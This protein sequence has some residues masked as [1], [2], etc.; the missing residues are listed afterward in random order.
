MET[1]TAEQVLAACG[2]ADNISR[3]DVCMTRLRVTVKDPSRLDCVQLKNIHRVLGI[4]RN[5]DSYV[6]IVFGPAI[7]EEVATD[8]SELTHK[9]VTNSKGETFNYHVSHEPAT[10]TSPTPARAHSY[11]VQRKA[12]IEAMSE[13]E[14]E[15]VL[16]MLA[17]N[18]DEDETGKRAASLLV[19]NGPN[20]NMLGIREPDIYGAQTYTDL[21]AICDAAGKQAGFSRVVVRQSNHE[22]TLVDEI[23][24]AYKSFDAI[25]INPGAYTHTSIAILDAL[26]A[27]GIPTVEVH[28]S[29][30]S[31]REDFRQVS[32]VRL[33][34][35]ATVM[36]EGLDGYAHAIRILAEH[37]GLN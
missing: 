4:R 6:E 25:V 26:K 32:Y 8:F 24:A 30:V 17:A 7:I 9:I 3:T 31:Q 10:L 11:A 37:I 20:I 18:E 34:A 27:V 1:T 16:S 19:L 29:D 14:L 21:V 28:I 23:Q 15:D 35:I 36:G 12:R 2:G 5:G 33:A 22:G 13:D